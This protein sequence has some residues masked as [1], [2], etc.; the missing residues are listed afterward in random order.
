MRNSTYT[1]H[2]PSSKLF[3]S[4]SDIPWSFSFRSFSS[5]RN[6][7]TCIGC[8][9][10]HTRIVRFLFFYISYRIGMDISWIQKNVNHFFKKVYERYFRLISFLSSP[11]TYLPL[12]FG[13]LVG[14]FH[15]HNNGNTYRMPSRTQRW[16]ALPR[17]SSLLWRSKTI[18]FHKFPAWELTSPRVI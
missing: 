8:C 1:Y 3:C 2:L 12:L 6:S 15:I 7:H 17:I 14:S 13:L 11:H 5:I 4:V 18:M 16:D 10:P 9:F